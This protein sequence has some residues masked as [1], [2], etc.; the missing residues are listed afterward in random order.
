MRHSWFQTVWVGALT[1]ALHLLSPGP[2]ALA[3]DPDSGSEL[4]GKA[5]PE[6]TFTRWVRGRSLSLRELRGKVVLVRWWTEGCRY[7]RS[8]LPV[9]ERLQRE[10]RGDLVVLGVFHSKP[11]PHEVSDRHILGIAKTLGWSGPVAFDRDWKTLDRY[12]L[13]ANP[14]R[15]WT[16]VS[17]LIDREGTIRW[18][19]GGGEYHPSDDPK[20]HACEVEYEGLEQALEHVLGERSS[21][22]SAG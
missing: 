18:V 21:A 7:C 17:F 14:E 1:L 6:W 15:S 19:H 12:W 13:G 20:H 11:E 8:T 3:Q 5:A 10:H 22:P 4:I 16:S 9:L 2:V